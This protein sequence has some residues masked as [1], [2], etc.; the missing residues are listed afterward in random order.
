MQTIDA[1]PKQ[2][3]LRM[4]SLDDGGVRGLSELIILQEIMSRLKHLGNLDSLPKPCDYFDIIGGTGT[5][6]VIALMLGRLHMPIDLAIKQYVLFSQ[7]VFS[8]IKK[9]SWA[10]KFKATA[11][12]SGMR[13]I[14]QCAG[15]SEDVL[16]EEDNTPCKSF[17]VALPSA[18]MTPRIFRTYKVEA[19]QGFNCTV[20]QAARAT[21]ATPDFF[22]P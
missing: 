1:D 17:V 6:G 16:M 12:E 21:T 13:S 20:V 19:N 14:I 15:F 10:E 5:G 11:F 9:W 7:E 2:R 3:G 18:N 4:L 22:K 8:D